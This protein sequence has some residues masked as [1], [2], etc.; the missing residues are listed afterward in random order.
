[1][2]EDVEGRRRAR[3]RLQARLAF[4]IVQTE[5]E[6][7]VGL[8]LVI[9]AACTLACS[10]SS[11]PPRVAPSPVASAGAT[12]RAPTSTMGTLLGLP[13]AVIALERGGSAVASTAG[14]SQVAAGGEV[15]TRPW[16]ASMP[17]A[18]NSIALG[19]TATGVMTAVRVGGNSVY[20][21]RPNAALEPLV[22]DGDAWQSDFPDLQRLAFV[23]ANGGSVLFAVVGQRAVNSQGEIVAWRLN[24]AGEVVGLP[25]PVLRDATSFVATA[26][27]GGAL[28]AYVRTKGTELSGSIAVVRVALGQGNAWSSLDGDPVDL[29]GGESANT[30]A[31]S[32]AISLDDALVCWA[33]LSSV[34]CA[35]VS[36]ITGAPKRPPFR[37]SEL[38]V[39]GDVISDA[40][41]PV[42]VAAHG[43][44]WMVV[45]R[46]VNG[47]VSRF[48]KA[49]ERFEARIEIDEIGHDGTIREVKRVSTPRLQQRPLAA[50]A[51]SATLFA[52]SV[53]DHQTAWWLLR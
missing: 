6:M 27:R 30:D 24:G 43:D 51:A 32:M 12:A 17:K 14:L 36:A 25:V 52:W 42:A 9:L 31:L 16:D 47:V 18:Q 50:G 13:E 2:E 1:M 38:K 29:N 5:V 3:W 22:R 11:P 35:I 49:A 39:D 8:P 37:L 41:S 45:R 48:D 33:E 34:R 10:P 26:R 23:R 19:E 40:S 46:L 4:A 28:V 7:N 20:L 53:D 44:G 21:L 15:S